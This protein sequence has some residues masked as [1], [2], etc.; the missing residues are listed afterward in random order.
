MVRDQPLILYKGED[1]PKKCSARKLKRFGLAVFISRI[2]SNSII[3]FSDSAIR[4]SPADSVYQHI[5]AIDI[6]WENVDKYH[7]PQGY[8]R[9]L[10]YMLAANPVNYGK[11]YKLSTVEALAASYFI[12]GKREVALRL[13]GKFS[14]GIQFINLNKNPLEDYSKAKDSSEIM[15]IEKLYF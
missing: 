3:L 7:F 13:L 14:W 9:S 12:L 4:L 6:S 1:D 2:P 10:P 11:P 8:V 15:E 5:V